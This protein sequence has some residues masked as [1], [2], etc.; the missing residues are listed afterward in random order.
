VTTRSAQVSPSAPVTIR[1]PFAVNSV[2]VARSRLRRWMLAHGYPVEHVDNARV[3]VSELLAN[4]IRH[5]QP[6]DD[7]TVLVTWCPIGRTLEISVTDGGGVTRPQAVEASAGAPAGRG[8]RVIEALSARWWS[9][10]TRAESTV[11]AV[12]PA[13]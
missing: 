8:L 10:R 4:A 5:A 6:L 11:H 1:V 13:S 7:G 3:I 9:E 2:A 12:L